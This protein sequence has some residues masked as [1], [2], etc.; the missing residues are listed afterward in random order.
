[1]E[2]QYPGVE[3]VLFSEHMA[4]SHCAI[5]WHPEA[6]ARPLT[7]ATI[8]TDEFI[9]E[10]MSSDDSRNTSSCCLR[11]DSAVCYVIY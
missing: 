10:D 8:G 3:N 2:V 11:P 4:M 1:M 9:I 6:A 7:F 5:S